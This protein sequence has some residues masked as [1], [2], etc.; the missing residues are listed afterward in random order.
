M[1][2]S[3]QRRQ[4]G[5]TLIRPSSGLSIS[6]WPAISRRIGGA[7]AVS[8]GAVNRP[9]PQDEYVETCVRYQREAAGDL[10][11]PHIAGRLWRTEGLSTTLGKFRQGDNHLNDPRLPRQVLPIAHVGFGAASAEFA[12]FDSGKLIEISE[13][14]CH[15]DYKLM[16][17][18]GV[19]SIVR[20]YEPGVFKKMSAMMGLIPKDAPEGPDRT[21]FYE[22]FL[23]R[24]SAEAQW[25]IVHGYGRLIAFSEMSIHAALDAVRTIP[26]ARQPAAVQGA[27]F[28]FA[29]MNSPDMAR[30]LDASFDLE[31]ASERAAFQQGLVSALVFCEWFAPGFLAAWKRSSSR[32]GRLIEHAVAESTANVERGYPLAFR[33]ANPFG[34]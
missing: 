34:T 17:L 5:W 10:S 28:A 22:S 12:R 30:I 24:F 18:E 7:G 13:T 2:G 8:S 27:A 9:V 19:G 1:I 23:A 16:M 21:G 14:L 20:I 29:M 15:P 26:A 4:G 32:E 3:M 31:A 25:L 6:L 11:M 33:L